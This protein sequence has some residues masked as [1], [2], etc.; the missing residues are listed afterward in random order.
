MTRKKI[1]MN[2][3]ATA[4][5][6][7]RHFEIHP[8]VRRIGEAIVENGGTPYLVGGWVRDRLL[9]LAD[10]QDYDLEVFKLSMRRLK[11][12]LL[13]FG[14]VHSVGRHFGVLKL[15]T[16]SAE[17]DVS[18]PRRESNIGK[19]HKGFRVTPDPTMTFDEAAAR[20]DFTIN[21][22]GYDFRKEVLLDPHGG[23]RDLETGVVRHVGPAFS[24]DPLRV[25]RAM[26]FAGRFGFRIAPDTQALCR[27]LNLEEL[28][29]ERIWEEIK[30]LLLQSPR[31][32]QGF[33]Y[34]QKLGV[35]KFF[36]ELQALHDASA[37]EGAQ[38]PWELTLAFLDQAAIAVRRDPPRGVVLMT[39]ALCYG[40]TQLDAAAP[41]GADPDG[42]APDGAA[43]AAGL[44][45]TGLF[46]AGEPALVAR[47]LGRLTNETRFIEGVMGLT[48]ELVKV[49][50]LFKTR[51]RVEDGEVRRLALRIEIPFLLKA[52]S[53]LHRARQGAAAFPAGNWLEARARALGVWEGPPEP[54]LKGRHLLKHGLKTGRGMG[55]MLDAVFQLQ[56]D[57]TIATREAALAWVVAHAKE[58]QWVE[59]IPPGGAP[60]GGA[61]TS[62]G[63]KR[64]G[65]GNLAGRG[66]KQ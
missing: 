47:F 53:A 34:A 66:D 23:E 4:N 65:G 24:E 40:L 58:T 54:L 28:P 1:N 43:E 7:E 41:D 31:P 18:V 50:V 37:S 32:S 42:A 16:D 63:R 25:L 22:M 61:P 27:R 44:F 51:D 59:D 38:S 13:P 48:A 29:R 36:P 12:I 35:L 8:E 11:E 62:G 46:T 20:R 45:A 14:P 55:N 21:A 60:T 30:K 49:Q 15:S 6:T 52:A 10:Q 19:G 64:S 33:G 3:H 56:L 57:G 5:S 17:Y 26:R 9:G 39:A 2:L